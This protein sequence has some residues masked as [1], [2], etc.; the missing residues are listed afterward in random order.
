MYDH[1]CKRL[2]ETFPTDFA[3]WIL[4]EPI[5]LTALQPSE[6][7]SEPIRADSLIFLE[8]SALILHLEFQTSPDENMPLRMLDYW[9][10]IR[11]RFPTREIHQTVIYLKPTNSNLVFQN[12]FTS[13]ETNHR[14]QII[15]MWE[16]LPQSLQQYQGLLPFVTLCQTDNPEELLR[17]AAQQ[18]EGIDDKKVQA[19]LITAA[20][21]ISGL[22]L[23]KEI[24]KRILRQEVMRESVTYQEILQEGE[25]K[26]KAEG[27]AEGL[28]RGKAETAR[29][30]ALNMLHSG[31]SVDLISQFTGLTLEQIQALQ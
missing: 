2:A 8:S 29:Q 19:D 30:I 5:P 10:R 27:L 9:V 18:I 17:Q 6:L 20:Y 3:S 26:G 14:F 24:A 28:A 7:S 13:A 11:R 4:G 21:V 31:I 22:T 1:S 15:R 12:S 16:Q 25:V 23:E